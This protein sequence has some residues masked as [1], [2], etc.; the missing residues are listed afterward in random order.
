MGKED[1]TLSEKIRQK[2]IGKPRSI[3]DPSLFHKL[4][5]I[6]ILAWIRAGGKIHD[7]AS[8]VSGAALL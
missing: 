7:P 5:L 8:F 2:L 6:P 4:A 3:K 1:L